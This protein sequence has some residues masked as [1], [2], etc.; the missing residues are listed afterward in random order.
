MN[1]RQAFS[2]EA[3]EKNFAMSKIVSN[4]APAFCGKVPFRVAPEALRRVRLVGPGREI[5]IL[6][7]AG[8]N[9]ARSTELKKKI[10]R[11]KKNYGTSQ[12][13]KEKNSF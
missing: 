13:C 9:P 5:F 4:F 11:I 10:D 7:I 2:T 8:S 1:K 12:V 3:V 6:K